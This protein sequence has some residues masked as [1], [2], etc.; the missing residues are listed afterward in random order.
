MKN[1]INN[2]IENKEL[3]IAGVSANRQKWGNALFRALTKK[4]YKIYPLNPKLD[5]VEGVKCYRSVEDLPDHIENIIMATSQL[6]TEEIIKQCKETGIKRIWMHKGGGGAGAQSEA[7]IKNARENN[8]EVV[9]GFCPMMFFPPTGIH[10][11][12]FWMKKISH[13]LPPEYL[14]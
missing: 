3:A 10:R 5:E 9:Y 6:A 14:N 2:F 8:M 4:G 13:N 1:T 7:A 12:H 11:L